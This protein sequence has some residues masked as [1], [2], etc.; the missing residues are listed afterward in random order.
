MENNKGFALYQFIPLNNAIEDPI[1]C[2]IVTK[3]N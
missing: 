1:N 2:L 3:N